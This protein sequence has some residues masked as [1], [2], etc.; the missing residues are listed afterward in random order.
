M[1]W[2]SIGRENFSLFDIA[3][4]MSDI[5]LGHSGP[6]W[7]SP[8]LRAAIE[9]L[10]PMAPWFRWSIYDRDQMRYLENY[11]ETNIRV[12]LREIQLGMSPSSSEDSRQILEDALRGRIVLLNSGAFHRSPRAYFDSEASAALTYIDSMLDLI[13]L[14]I[15]SSAEHEN[16]I[17]APV[18]GIIDTGIRRLNEMKGTNRDL[19]MRRLWY[20]FSRSAAR[21]GPVSL[22][23]LLDREE[24]SLWSLVHTLDTA[25]YPASIFTAKSGNAVLIS[26]YLHSGDFRLPL[27]VGTVRS[28]GCNEFL[29]ELLRTAFPTGATEQVVLAEGNSAISAVTGIEVRRG[30]SPSAIS[31]PPLVQEFAHI[32]LPLPGVSASAPAAELTAVTFGHSSDGVE[33]LPQFAAVYSNEIRMASRTQDQSYSDFPYACT[34]RLNLTDAVSDYSE[35]DV[36]IIRSTEYT[37]SLSYS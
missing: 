26:N 33:L 21:M 14:K 32:V 2:R 3:S 16:Q 12:P 30:A 5:D 24:R 9:S 25:G 20:L 27:Q 8:I 6:R 10:V 18:F 7:K 35:I 22:W 34:F 23:N 15:I 11:K 29:A 17:L 13:D 28:D 1:L 36:I 31:M 4:H 19:A 37:S